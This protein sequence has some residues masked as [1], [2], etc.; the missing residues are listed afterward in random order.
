MQ[1]TLDIPLPIQPLFPST[2]K[3]A[4]IYSHPKSGPATKLYASCGSLCK[5]TKIAHLQT[6]LGALHGCCKNKSIQNVYLSVHKP[7]AIFLFLIPFSKKRKQSSLKK[8]LTSELGQQIYKMSLEPLII[9]ESKEVINKIKQ[10]QKL[11][12]ICQRALEQ[13]GTLLVAQT[14]TIWAMKFKNWIWIVTQSL[15]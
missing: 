7:S 1:A 14:K 9:Q 11:M 15:K 8:Q 3:G 13:L 12:G 4:W 10:N 5:A 2:L 6:G